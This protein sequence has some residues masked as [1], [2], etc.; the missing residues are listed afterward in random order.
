MGFWEDY[1]PH[2]WLDPQ[3]KVERAFGDVYGPGRQGSGYHLQG[4]TVPTI[5][6]GI[7]RGLTP[8]F[9]NPVEG[10]LHYVQGVEDYLAAERVRQAMRWAGNSARCVR[11]AKGSKT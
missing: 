10:A 3:V 6:D 9:P 8:R 11:S 4:R 1:F 5:F 2:D 7:T